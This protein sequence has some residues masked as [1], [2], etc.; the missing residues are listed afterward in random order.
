MRISLLFFVLAFVVSG[1]AIELP[2]TSALVTDEQ[3]LS[4]LDRDF[5]FTQTSGAVPVPVGSAIA[6]LQQPDFLSRVQD[7]YADTLPP[8]ESPEFTI[9][10]SSPTNWYFINAKR[11]RTDITEAARFMTRDGVFDLAY[12]TEGRRFFGNYRALIHIRLSGSGEATD[13]QAAVYAYPENGISRFFARHLKLVERYFHSKTGEISEIALHIAARL[14]DTDSFGEEPIDFSQKE[15]EC[16]EG[17]AG[18]TAGMGVT[19]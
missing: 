15:T 8:G 14:C 12:Y 9:N 5:I 6:V 4:L 3:S 16:N 19:A 17:T 13:Y 18:E 11:E 7:E 2:E 1:S 10:Q